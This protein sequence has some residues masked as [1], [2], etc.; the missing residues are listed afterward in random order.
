M[1]FKTLNNNTLNDVFWNSKT[2][3]SVLKVYH[4]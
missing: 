2:L 3:N 4:A 1:L